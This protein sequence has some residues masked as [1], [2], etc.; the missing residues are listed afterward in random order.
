MKTKNM[1]TLT[2]KK[3]NWP[4]AFAA[5]LSSHRVCALP[6]FAFS[7]AARAVTPAPDGGYPGAN[8]AEGNN[9]LLN[10]TSGANNTALG[11]NALLND[12]TGSLN[13]ASGSRALCEQHHWRSKHSH[14]RTGAH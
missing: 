3:I 2:L 13:T 11:F 7:P 6:A 12:S 8:T 1:T 10:L 4:V 9:A 14:W 5:R